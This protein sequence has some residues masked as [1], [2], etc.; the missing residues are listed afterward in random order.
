M[1]FAITL[2]PSAQRD[3]YRVQAYY[4]TEAPEQTER[5]TDEFFAVARRVQEFPHSAPTVRGAARRVN[6]RIFPYQIWYR[7][8]D[9]AQVVEIIAVL[10]HRQDPSRLDV[11][12]GDD[13]R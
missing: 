1:T 8:R 3:F 2:S 7:V 5:F 13:R 11:D 12:H 10:H 4:D 6:L 9:E